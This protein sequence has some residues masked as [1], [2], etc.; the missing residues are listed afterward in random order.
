MQL[1]K[2]ALGLFALNRHSYCGGTSHSSKRI[3]ELPLNAITMKTALK[4]SSAFCLD[5]WVLGFS[6]W[7]MKSKQLANVL[8]KIIGLYVCLCAIPGLVSGILI[9]VSY[10]WLIEG[11]KNRYIGTLGYSIGAAVQV[12]IGIFLITK[13]RKLAQY[14]FK[15]EDE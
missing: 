5:I 1:G 7:G 15:N 2:F 3:F 11:A 10:A 4:K 6:F 12:A 9:G 14:W 13:S 8:I